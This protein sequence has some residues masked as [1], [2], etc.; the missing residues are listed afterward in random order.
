MLSPQRSARR[1][2]RWSPLAIGVS[3][4]ATITA[5]GIATNGVVQRPAPQTE[6]FKIGPTPAPTP[7]KVLVCYQDPGRGKVCMWVSP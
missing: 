4:L 1:P 6:S 5:V 7:T 3:L 2:H